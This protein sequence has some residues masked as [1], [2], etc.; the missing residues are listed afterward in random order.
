MNSEEKNKRYLENIDLMKNDFKRLNLFPDETKLTKLEVFEV[1]KTR[2]E[3]I[4]NTLKNKS[5][6]K[7]IEYLS[8]EE[9]FIS[10]L[11]W[12]RDISQFKQTSNGYNAALLKWIEITK[13]QLQDQFIVVGRHE[14]DGVKKNSHRNLEIFGYAKL[15]NEIEDLYYALKKNKFIGSETKSKQLYDVLSDK[16]CKTKIVWTGSQ[17]DLALFVSSIMGWI[18]DKNRIW[19]RV[20]EL[21]IKEDG[22]SFSTEG[23]A[24]PNDKKALTRSSL[25]RKEIDSL[26]KKSELLRRG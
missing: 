8:E 13:R 6:R 19:V 18:V 17:G 1:L 5:L 7:K 9:Y 26:L 24:K 16:D 22:D 4:E 23:L 21:F 25:L 12:F 15:N 11:D 3:E 10:F 14:R 2:I 20:S